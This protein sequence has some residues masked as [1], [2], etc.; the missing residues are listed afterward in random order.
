MSRALTFATAA[1]LC[2][3]GCRGDTSPRSEAPS[4]AK[5]GS[6]GPVLVELYT[7]QGCSSCPPADRVLSAAGDGAFGAAVIP[8][9]FHVDYW[10]HIGWRDPFS[11]AEYSARQR[12][13]GRTLT[14]GRVYT[15]MAVVDGRVHLVGSNHEALARAIEAARR[16]PDPWSLSLAG[17][18]RDGDRIRARLAVR[19]PE[20]GRGQVFVAVAESGLATTVGRGENAGRQLENDHIVRRLVEVPSRA[21]EHAVEIEIDPSWRPEALALVAF[22]QDPKDMAILGATAAR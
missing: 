7:S 19:R 14:A 13:Y 20:A 5:A 15:P 17:L 11:S 8:L 18:E 3:A 6:A 1:I 22:A 12:R 10:D 4:S 16:R 21:G 9:A 2:A